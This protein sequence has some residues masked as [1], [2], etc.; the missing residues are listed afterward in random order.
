MAAMALAGWP[1]R[2]A[3]AAAGR[4]PNILVFLVDDMGWMDCGAYGSKYYDTPNI[5]RL[6]KQS[7][8][9][10]DAYA[11]PLCSPTRAS[12]L[13]GQ[14]SPRHGV[15]SASGHQP[16]QP[17]GHA[18]LP[19]SAPP[20]APL[21][22]PESRN[23][24]EPSQYTLAE[25]LRD[26]GYRTGHFGKWH[27]GLT[28]P[29]WPEE[30]GFG[31]AFHCHPDPGP[32]GG[33]FSPYEVV[34]DGRPTGKSR[35][36][37]ITDGPPGKY[38]TDRLTD[39]AIRFIET[40]EDRPFF[41]NL[42]HYGVH[43]PWGHKDA[44][45]AEFAGKSDPS[46]LQGNPIMASMLRS[47]D[48]SLGRVVAALDRLGLAENT[49]VLFASDNGGNVHSNTPEDAK[50]RR[51]KP[52]DPALADW[53]RWAGGLPPTNNAPLR[54]GK[55]SLY[56]GGIRV[57]LMVRWPGEIAP[58][59]TSDAVVGAIDHYPTLLDLAG[60]PLPAAQKVDGVSYAPVLKGS[61][62]LSR[63]AYFT[64]FP[65]LVPGV[66]VRRG[67]WKLIRRFTERQEY[68]GLHELFNLRDDLGETTNLAARH[69]ETVKE[70]DALIDTFVK[71][72]GAL[73]PKPNPRYK[74]R[75]ADP[76]EGLVP[77]FCKITLAA[78]AL[79]VEAD[80]RTP[81]LGIAGLRDPGPMTLKL[82][83]RSAAGG[84]GEVH[85]RTV[86]QESFPA[87]QSVKFVVPA[88]ADWQDLSLKLPIQGQAG[89][90]RLYLPAQK[91][92]VEIQSLQFL[93]A[94][95]GKPVRAWSFTSA[96]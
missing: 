44:Y 89:I 5:D 60:V 37:T 71:E 51:R 21:L 87:E 22:M 70:L 74:P 50:T 52:D 35:V 76:T 75:T 17:P 85:W 32:P 58:G 92:P 43:G 53:R 7:M 16:P 19:E 68:E 88:G 49:I 46:G 13:T 30:Q 55:A 39:E 84:S 1:A 12:I 57:P 77:R 66:A 29:H 34:S 36:G 95:S 3:G 8:R 93:A 65:H 45:T 26:A 4:K 15:T 78:G 24:L 25:A 28:Q 20:N 56:E 86:G 63:E 90:V 11:L 61:G 23:Y 59:T 69:P 41:L 62:K 14:H 38:I 48:E 18:F 83:I 73:Y 2:A 72:T 81:F 96:K 40:R 80:G 6:A 67:D 64:W 54:G 47:V 9:F 27:I 94:E 91:A 82:R 10:T 31:T 42:W 79:R 33:Y